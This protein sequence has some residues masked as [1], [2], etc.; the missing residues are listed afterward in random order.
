[1]SLYHKALKLAQEIN[2]LSAE[3]DIVLQMS[4]TQQ[5]LG[6]YG[7]AKDGLEKALILY[8]KLDNSAAQAMTGCD[9][10]RLYDMLGVDE[11]ALTCYEYSLAIARQHGFADVI[12]AAL[13]AIGDLALKRRAF[14]SARQ[15]YQECS[16]IVTRLDDHQK[17]SNISNSMALVLLFT[18]DIGEAQTEAERS[19]QLA[20]A[21]HDTFAVSFA[22]S[23]LCNITQHQGDDSAYETYVERLLTL[24]R[25][26]GARPRLS[27]AMM[28]KA[29]AHLRAGAF[30]EAATLLHEALTLA[31]QIQA[32]LAQQIGVRCAVYMAALRADDRQAAK[33]SAA[34]HRQW[35]EAVIPF[36]Y[37]D[38]AL[39]S[40]EQRLGTQEY[41][42]LAA[43]GAAQ[44][45]NIT[46]LEIL[47]Y[48]AALK[49]V[50][51]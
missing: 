41:Q 47:S 5:R 38:K 16:R 19:L 24:A 32:A 15:Y 18:G 25:Q 26:S 50:E 37:L 12:A 43:E 23:C 2:D 31:N 27:E 34:V 45:S 21:S 35:I 39:A 3:A 40:V 20:E 29:M 13:L 11:R 48:C 51:H 36:N 42:R 30:D 22:L 6:E 17:L 46:I 14:S 1:M 7:A 4:Q 9:L 44:G 28:H 33:W 49:V 10:G 8:E